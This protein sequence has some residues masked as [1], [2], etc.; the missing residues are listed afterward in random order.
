VDYL[1]ASKPTISEAV[2]TLALQHR[3]SPVSGMAEEAHDVCVQWGMNPAIAL[4]FFIHESGAG[5]QGI[6]RLTQNWGNLRE[7]KRAHHHASGFAWYS[8][9]LSSL[10]DFCDLLLGPL[11]AG[12]GLLHVSE[13]TP[14][15]A[16]SSDQND[17]AAYAV[18]VNQMVATW[19]TLS[20]V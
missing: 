11:Y 7:G 9:F 1:I 5:T 20:G 12:S 8:N 2:F 14:R 19:Q 4:A 10:D 17:P 6:A 15:Y 16:P 3:Q 18:A 13:V